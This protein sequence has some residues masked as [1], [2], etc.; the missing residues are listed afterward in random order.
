MLEKA[1]DRVPRKLV[2]W[3]LKQQGIDDQMIQAVRTLYNASK[4]MVCIDTMN[5]KKYGKEFEVK[6]G[7][8][9]DQYLAHYCSLQ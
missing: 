2:W 6:V 5:G 1:Y 9:R 3:A 7:V 8:H 4:S